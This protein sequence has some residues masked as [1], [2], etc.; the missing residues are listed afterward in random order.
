MRVRVV[1]P[2]GSSVA[3]IIWLHGL[4]QSPDIMVRV[5][6]RMGLV[7][8][9][10]RGVFPAAPE[11]M[12]GRLREEPVAAWFDQNVFDLRRMDLGSALAMEMELRSLVAKEAE[13]AGHDRVLI[14][15]FSQGAA[16]GLMLGMRC[17]EQISGM[18]L[19]ASYLPDELESLLSTSRK[20]PTH[21]PVWLGHGVH[22]F[23][24]PSRAG[25][26]VRDALVAWGYQVTWQSYRC[27][28]ESFGR[29][30]YGVRPFLEDAVGLK[31]RRDG[32]EGSL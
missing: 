4:G 20:L 28:H 7:G 21:V 12:A 23:V 16:A 5:A 22:D 10:V 24:I 30:R 6:R 29:V 32:L 18:M 14:A 15:G 27:G 2:S 11:R 8:R 26:H 31:L 3:T 9:G 13:L 1:A 25:E 17:T 19:Y